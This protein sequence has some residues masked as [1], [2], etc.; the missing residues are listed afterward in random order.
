MW[1]INGGEDLIL[2]DLCARCVARADRLLNVHGGRDRA[3]MRLT[4]SDAAA[5][6]AL[7]RV[8]RVSG[9]LMRGAVYIL[10]ALAVF[11]VV[12]LITSLR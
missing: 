4:E 11:F 3:A 12:T 8:R 10:I 1:R 2:A 5:A 7:S 6:T 9:A